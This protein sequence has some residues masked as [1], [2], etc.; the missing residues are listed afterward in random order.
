VHYHVFPSTQMN[1]Q[2]KYLLN[3]VFKYF[4]NFLRFSL[5]MWTTRSYGYT[6]PNLK[7][8]WA[9]KLLKFLSIFGIFWKYISFGSF[10]VKPFLSRETI[11]YIIKVSLHS[12]GLSWNKIFKIKSWHLQH[13][14]AFTT[15][16]KNKIANESNIEFNQVNPNGKIVIKFL[17]FFNSYALFVFHEIVKIDIKKPNL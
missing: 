15:Y 16:S 1:L 10:G 9:N 7:K 11:S 4:S 6:L 17:F 2:T 13:S 5:S 12:L 8:K 3:C 14:L